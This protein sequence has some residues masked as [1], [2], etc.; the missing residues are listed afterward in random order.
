MHALH[1]LGCLSVYEAVCVPVWA[2]VRQYVWLRG[3]QC[4]SVREAVWQCVCV[5][6]HVWQSAWQCVAVWQ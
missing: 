4:V 1:L 6:V 5:A 3:W 2:S